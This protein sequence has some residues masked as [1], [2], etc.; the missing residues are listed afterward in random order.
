MRNW[1][2]Y[3]LVLGLLLLVAVP[4]MA[5]PGRAAV[6]L[7]TPDYPVAVTSTFDVVIQVN[8]GGAPIDAAAAYLNFD[9][10]LFE[11]VRVQ[12]GTTLPIFLQSITD[13]SIG[14]VDFAAG[15]LPPTY[16]S[17][18][19]TLATVT[20]RALAPVDAGLITL[21]VGSDALRRTDVTFAGQSVIANATGAV[22]MVT[23]DALPP[24]EI[25]TAPRTGLELPVE[26]G[27]I[28]PVTPLDQ[29]AAPPEFTLAA[30]PPPFSTGMD[31]ADVWAADGGWAQQLDGGVSGAD[32]AASGVPGTS[33][34]RL[35]QPID[36]STAPGAQV[37]FT[38]RMSAQ[39]SM[40]R[41][42]IRT[43]I[44]PTWRPLTQL[45]PAADWTP[46]VV[47]VSAYIG[48]VVEFRFVWESSEGAV[49]D[50][51]ALDNLSVVSTGVSAPIEAPAELPA[52]PEEAPGALE[53]LPSAG[54]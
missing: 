37:A 33:S 26:I 48:Q 50:L 32:W 31:A 30:V 17:E 8:P 42:E 23:R 11:V 22:V 25:A 6:T 9:P 4:A 24:P 13:N 35:A 15:Q 51:W 53:N 7:I 36:L 38:Y 14:R 44:N 5:Q 19:F 29:V 18:S 28:E 10:S 1:S 46:L 39:A 20:L 2:R 41:L 43:A 3:I 34:L 49:G 12:P 54:G 45:S 21:N 40:G 27:A 47:D 16:P 52:A